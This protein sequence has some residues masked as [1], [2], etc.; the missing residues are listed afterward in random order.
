ML[1]LALVQL[2][3]EGRRPVVPP[4]AGLLEE[5]G[6]VLC[7]RSTPLLPQYDR[8]I[9]RLGETVSAYPSNSG[10]PIHSHQSYCSE[11]RYF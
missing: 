5:L 9:H 11:Q 10:F 6:G 7:P 2:L 4:Q 1:D 3:P 8:G